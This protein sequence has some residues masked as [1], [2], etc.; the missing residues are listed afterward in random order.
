MVFQE[1]EDAIN[2]VN[3]DGFEKYIQ[4]IIHG[5]GIPVLDNR[6]PVWTDAWNLTNAHGFLFLF[7][8]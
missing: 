1:L 4:E 6:Q 3:F 7:Y 5:P 8:L 2:D